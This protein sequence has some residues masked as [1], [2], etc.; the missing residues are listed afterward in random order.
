MALELDQQ[1]SGEGLQ[2]LRL[3]KLWYQGLWILD[4][5]SFSSCPW[6]EV[7]V[8]ASLKPLLDVAVICWDLVGY[9]IVQGGANMPLLRGC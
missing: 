7:Q 1:R 8:Q 9:G 4:K 6:T 3:W 5:G 2:L